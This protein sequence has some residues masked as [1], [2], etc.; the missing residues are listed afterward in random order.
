MTPPDEAPLA[1]PNERLA[2]FVA[3]SLQ[4]RGYI[5]PDQV[6]EVRQKV[7]LGTA[8]T[9]DWRLWVE[10]AQERAQREREDGTPEVSAD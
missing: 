8:G 1:T 10:I 9:A 4:E 2:A 3:R 7:A 5:T 6:D